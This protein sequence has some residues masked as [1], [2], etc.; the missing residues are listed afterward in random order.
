[1]TW[2]QWSAATGWLATLMVMLAAIAG[3]FTRRLLKAAPLV[4]RMRPHYVIGYAALAFATLHGFFAMGS[5]R[6]ADSGGLRA[7]AVAI[8]AL[9]IQ[10]FV[11]ASLQ[12]PGSYR[13]V[14]R[15]WHIAF[16]VALVLLVGYHVMVNAAFAP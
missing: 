1:M 15:R 3:A 16:F 9:G 12:D 10:T 14:L 13:R 6:G 2:V 5:M 11:G 8:L 4:H 7:A